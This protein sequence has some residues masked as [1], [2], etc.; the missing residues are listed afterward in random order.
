MSSSNGYGTLDQLRGIKRMERD[1]TKWDEMKL[2]LQALDD[3]DLRRIRE[4]IAA[5]E[6]ATDEEK[7]ERDRDASIAFALVKPDLHAHDD[8][9]AAVEVVRHIPL[10]VRRMLSTAI[11]QMTWVDPKLVGLSF[12]ADPEPQPT[13]EITASMSS[14]S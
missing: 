14:A 3:A 11:V 4:Y 10:P 7:A 9:D 12:F 8:L 1:F 5:A 6:D 13:E 2:R